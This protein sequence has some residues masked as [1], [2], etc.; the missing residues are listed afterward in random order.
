VREQVENRFY[1]F[2]LFLCKRKSF[3][4][5]AAATITILDG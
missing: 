3:H 5:A 1:L 4:A 2:L